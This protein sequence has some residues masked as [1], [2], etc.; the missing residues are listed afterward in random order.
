MNYLQNLKIVSVDDDPQIISYMERHVAP[1]C[2]EFTPFTS[3]TLALEKMAVIKPDILISDIRMPLINGIELSKRVLELGMDI[4]IVLV[5]ASDDVEHLVEAINIGIEKFVVKPFEMSKLIGNLKKIGRQIVLERDAEAYKKKLELDYQ[6][7]KEELEK[8][9]ISIINT[10]G[11]VVETRSKETAYHV[12]RV[13]S[14]SYLIG[15]KLG[16]SE[17]D[18]YLLERASPLHDVG[19]IGIPDHILNKPAALSED[20]YT[21][22]KSHTTIGYEILKESKQQILKSASI[23][24]LQHHEAWSGGGYPYG[25]KGEEIHI[26]ARI[27]AVADVFDAL[28]NSRC[29]REAWSIERSLDFI[30]Q[31]RG[32]SFD[33]LVVDIFLDS[34]EDVV[35]IMERYKDGKS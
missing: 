30:A 6:A 22:I 21:I 15:E 23:I 14:F 31:K 20:E 18:R 25:I 24:A 12:Y 28:A 3:P 13:A 16:L 27:T 17:W 33:P 9:Q 10:L 32:V 35:K 11:N 7:L 5:S 2:L 34:I 19:K 26:F 8:T 4:K 29:Y 1:L